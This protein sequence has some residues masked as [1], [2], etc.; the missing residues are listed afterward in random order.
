MKAAV[1][2]L[3]EVREELAKVKWP[4]KPEVVKLTLLVFAISAILGAYLG[5]LD[6]AFTKFLEYLISR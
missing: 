4:K 3:R 2:Y 1:N 5:A 6:F